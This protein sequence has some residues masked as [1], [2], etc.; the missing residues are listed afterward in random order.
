MNAFNNTIFPIFAQI[1]KYY[2]PKAS[3]VQYIYIINKDYEESGIKSDHTERVRDVSPNTSPNSNV[4]DQTGKVSVLHR[5]P[6]R[7][8]F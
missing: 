1:W 5:L 6:F 3:L 2:I 8:M 7:I 4:H